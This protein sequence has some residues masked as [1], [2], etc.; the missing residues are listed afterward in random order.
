MVAAKPF[1]LRVVTCRKLIL[2]LRAQIVVGL[3]SF[4]ALRMLKSPPSPRL[5]GFPT[6]H[7]HRQQRSISSDIG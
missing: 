5:T 2:L 3:N 4:E 6:D 7:I 1:P